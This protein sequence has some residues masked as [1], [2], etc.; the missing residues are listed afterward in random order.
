VQLLGLEEREMTDYG[1]VD[2][3]VWRMVGEVGPRACHSCSWLNQVP[4]LS[5]ATVRENQHAAKISFGVTET[6]MP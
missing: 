1:H 4:V 3:Q 6:T 5:N 2:D